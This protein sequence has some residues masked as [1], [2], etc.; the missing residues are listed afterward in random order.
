MSYPQGY[1]EKGSR[2][3]AVVTGANTSLRANGVGERGL[4]GARGH[5]CSPTQHG[6]T[7][8]PSPAPPTPLPVTVDDGARGGT[9]ALRPRRLHVDAALDAHLKVELSPKAGNTPAHG[10]DVVRLA[11]SETR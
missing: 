4:P 10:V 7:L 9:P 3:P 5:S 6:H 2:S 1:K 11:G 8:A